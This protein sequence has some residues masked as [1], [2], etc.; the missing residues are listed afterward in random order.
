M[1]P[2]HASCLAQWIVAQRETHNPE[3]RDPMVCEVCL[4]PYNVRME[5][6]IACTADTLCSPESLVQ[7][8]SCFV[9]LLLVP[10]LV[11]M[12]FRSCSQATQ[13]SEKAVKNYEDDLAVAS[14]LCAENGHWG[15]VAIGCLL[16]VLVLSTMKKAWERWWVINQECEL[17]PLE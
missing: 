8:A 13:V 12:L 14:N 2:V 10:L 9:V 7:Y 17:R 16:M 6:T 1:A 11:L 3:E 15:V 4:A 5:S